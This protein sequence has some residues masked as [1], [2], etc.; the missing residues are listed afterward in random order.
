MHLFCFGLGYSALNLATSLLEQGWRVSG[1]VRTAAKGDNLKKL[2][3]TSY[4]L[5]DGLPLQEIWDLNSVTHILHSIPPVNSAENEDVNCDIVYRYHLG[6]IKKLPKLQWFGYLSTTGVYG[7][8]KGGWVDETTPVNPTN[9]RSRLRVIAE[10]AWLSAGLPVHIFRLSGIYGPGR[11]VLDE[12]KAGTA[13][14]IY[15]ENQ[16]FSRI[17]VDDINQ[18]LQKSMQNPQA[19]NIYNCADDEPAPQEEIVARAAKLLGL[20][21]PPLVDFDKADLS[22]MAKSFWQ[23]NRRV[24]NDKIKQELGVRLKYKN[25]KDGMSSILT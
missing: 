13:R 5:G 7:D 4:I 17:H 12:L 3:I 25:W 11:S 14:R 10:N 24:R 9:K 6:D 1:T 15:K 23:S 19:G 2:G 20:P 22:E 16:V 8:H 21:I 18:I